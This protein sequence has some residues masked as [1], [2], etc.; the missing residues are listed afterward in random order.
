MH[1]SY[2]IFTYMYHRNQPFMEVNIPF[3]PWIR[4]GIQKGSLARYIKLF[5]WAMDLRFRGELFVLGKCSP[6]TSGTLVHK[7]QEYI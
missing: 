2:G 6:H 3:V 1:G 4:H 7:F 5:H